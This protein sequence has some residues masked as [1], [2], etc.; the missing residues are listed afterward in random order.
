MKFVVAYDEPS[1]LAI[2]YWPYGWLSENSAEWK[3]ETDDALYEDAIYLEQ[4]VPMHLAPAEI[5][6]KQMACMGLH[7]HKGW[8][9]YAVYGDVLREQ[10]FVCDDSMQVLHKA[11]DMAKA[12]VKIKE[13]LQNAN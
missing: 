12:V 4:N 11:S 9:V 7:F 8:P 1:G 6:G 3:A 13:L 2:N 5:N 10:Y